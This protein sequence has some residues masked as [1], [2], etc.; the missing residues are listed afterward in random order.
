[1]DYDIELA[2]VFAPLERIDCGA[3]V[4]ACDVPWW[5]RTLCEVGGSLLRVG[6]FL[7]DFHWHVHDEEDEVFFVL[8]GHL[9][10]DLEDADGTPRTVELDPR[11][12]L[13]VPRGTR[14]RPRAKVRTV[15]LM[16]EPA[17]VAPTGDG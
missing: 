15:V 4:D 11:Q 13:M 12:G 8:E 17:T 7:G 1:M 6:V 10:L 16:V 3:L 5:N 9:F 14:H 2:P